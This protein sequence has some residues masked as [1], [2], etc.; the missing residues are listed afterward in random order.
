M[1]IMG[2]KITQTLIVETIIHQ[3]PKILNK[4]DNVNQDEFDDDEEEE[5]EE[6]ED[7]DIDYL[8]NSMITVDKYNQQTNINKTS[9]CNCNSNSDQC[10]QILNC[11]MISHYWL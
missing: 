7:F 9:N 10:N 5:E 6:E 4:N 2:V 1:T 3:S 8:V 11:G